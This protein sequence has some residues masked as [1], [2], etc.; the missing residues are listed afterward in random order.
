[1]YS[2]WPSRHL[3]TIGHRHHFT[4]FFNITLNYNSTHIIVLFHVKYA[5]LSKHC[6][7]NK[8]SFLRFLSHFMYAKCCMKTHL[9]SREVKIVLEGMLSCV[10]S[11]H[12]F[13]SAYTLFIYAGYSCYSNSSIS[14]F[15]S[16]LRIV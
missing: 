11:M 13:L 14:F 1:V 9:L 2:R 4:F 12:W 7:H 8:S 10:H 5:H 6:C 16:W 15:T 3:H